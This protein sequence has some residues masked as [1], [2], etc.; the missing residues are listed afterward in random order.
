MR[1]AHLPCTHITQ[2]WPRSR[3]RDMRV[4]S[5]ICDCEGYHMEVGVEARAFSSTE[6]HSYVP[7]IQMYREFA[8]RGN[9]LRTCERHQLLPMGPHMGTQLSSEVSVFFQY[10]T[11]FIES[12]C[13]SMRVH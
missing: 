3:P 13:H 1:E 11:R 2:A 7:L 5:E 12:A 8:N 4:L 10:V 6:Y 9:D